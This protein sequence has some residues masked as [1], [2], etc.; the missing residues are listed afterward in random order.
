VVAA[1]C[2]RKGDILILAI[3]ALAAATA[4]QP[5][6]RV[7]R[8]AEAEFDRYTTRV[9]E[10]IRH[11]ESS[12]VSFLSIPVGSA[13]ERTQREARL[14][15]GE[16]LIEKS[17]STPADVPGGLIHDWVG[18]VFMPHTG[19]AQALSVVQ[20]Y[21]HL[22][23]HYAPEVTA[24]RLLSHTGDDF[25]I[26][27]RTREHKVIT[28]VLDAEYDVHYGRL[29]PTHQ[30]SFSRSTKIT[31]VADVGTQHEHAVT[32]GENHGYLWRLNAYWRFVEAPDGVFVECEAVSLTRNVP[33]GL[34][35]LIGPFIESIPRESL[36]A[37]LMHTRDAAEKAK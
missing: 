29:D 35:W 10:T 12:V 5:A 1:F 8:E 9:E 13:A 17:G 30:F 20:D 25:H 26:L 15:Q 34:G 6:V 23:N 27:I 37:T 11:E 7:A 24:S 36:R 3:T 14:R 2:A 22:T 4:S 33:T 19:L 32:E 31:E 18:V 21:D 28:V 16:V